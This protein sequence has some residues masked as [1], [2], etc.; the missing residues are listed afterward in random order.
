VGAWA[1][2]RASLSRRLEGELV[3]DEAER[4]EKLERAFRRA[5]PGTY[6]ASSSAKRGEVNDGDQR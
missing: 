2:R 1:A 6:L 5:G 3:A 4:I